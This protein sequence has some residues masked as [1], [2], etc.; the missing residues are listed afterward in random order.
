MRVLFNG[1][2]SDRGTVT[3]GVP[4]GSIL[5]LMLFALHLNDLPT[6]VKY[7]ILGLYADY[8]GMHCSHSNLG[9]VGAHV[10]YDL[11]AMVLWLLSS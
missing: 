11:G 1:D 2:L 7:S 8:A 6:V 4:Q 9:V 10:Q 3:I 5:D